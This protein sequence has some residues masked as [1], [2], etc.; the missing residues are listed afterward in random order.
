MGEAGLVTSTEEM[1]G[2]IPFC[3]RLRHD[4]SVIFCKFSLLSPLAILLALL[5]GWNEY[6]LL[7]G[8]H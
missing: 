5:A 6:T 1:M 2:L 3:T 4:Y 8:S 7:L